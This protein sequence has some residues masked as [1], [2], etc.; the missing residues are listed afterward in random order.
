MKQ[1]INKTRIVGRPGW[2]AKFPDFADAPNDSPLD[3]SFDIGDR[4]GQI[5]W[6]DAPGGSHLIGFRFIDARGQTTEGRLR[7]KFQDG[8]SEL[9]VRFKATNGR[10]ASQYSYYFSDHSQGEGVFEM[11]KSAEH[12]GEIVHSE[13]IKKGVP[14]SKTAMT[15]E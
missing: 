3:T 11:M 2:E 14:Y 6:T 7:R 12:P 1:P 15:S 10:G 8:R 4:P 5:P 13:L 9:Q